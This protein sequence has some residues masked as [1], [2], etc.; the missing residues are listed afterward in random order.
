MPELDSPLTERRKQTRNRIFRYIYGFPDGCSKNDI[1]RDLNLSL[2][3][4]YQ[5]I[6][7][8]MD[9]GLIAYGGYKGSSGGRPAS[10]IQPVY[11][12]RTAV[13]VC[14]S[15]RD[16]RFAAT[17]LS[18]TET[19]YKSVPL[20]FPSEIEEI[21]RFMT[22]QLEQFLD[23]FH[24][25]RSTLIGVG[26][27]FP[28]II[29]DSASHLLYAPTLGIKNVSLDGL[30][31]SIPYTVHIENDAT[32]GG[33]AEIYNS[34]AKRNI[35]FLSLF[36]GVGGSLIVD[37]ELYRGA[38]N[39]SGEFG[40]MCVENGGRPC[41]CGRRGCLE[42][43]CSPRRLR[44][45]LNLTFEEF[46]S[47]LEAGDPVCR[48]AWEQFESHL[49]IGIHNLRMAFD[50]EVVLGGELSGYLAAHLPELRSRVAA[51]D[52]FSE[53]VSY[54]SVSR[55]SRYSSMLG[56]ALYFIKEFMDNI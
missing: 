8:L 5:N 49:A 47:S 3:T 13:G 36:E 24:I 50:S 51:L 56:A 52:P 15:C 19:G 37:G 41:T 53:D 31:E 33:L 46:F 7:E 35:A 1:A 23:E 28:G 17:D 30:I 21:F 45:D 34:E 44:D 20:R 22:A 12:I 55:Y 10:M 43:Y 26:I 32:A 16:L 6:T 4:V 25:D 11:N 27:T 29:D 2:P 14:L 42:A 40:H 48:D 39:R 38:N 9:A 54:L 18:G